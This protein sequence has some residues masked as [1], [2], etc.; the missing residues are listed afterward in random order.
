MRHNESS[1]KRKTHS[2]K[3]IQKETGKSL[4]Q[5]LDSTAESSK[6]KEANTSKSSRWQEIIK[7]MAEV[8]QIETKGTIQRINQTG[9]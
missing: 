5:Q 9:S 3:C 1:P 8:N 6:Q 4:H 7:C 2:S